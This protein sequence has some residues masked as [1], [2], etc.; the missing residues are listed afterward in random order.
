MTEQDPT[1]KDI[2]A[3]EADVEGH[4]IEDAPELGTAYH[5]INYGCSTD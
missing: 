3:A 4:G 5:D 2:E 1:E